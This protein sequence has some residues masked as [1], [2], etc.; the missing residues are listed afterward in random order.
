MD[1]LLAKLPKLINY[2]I[3]FF[4][5]SK[6]FLKFFCVQER[7]ILRPRKKILCTILQVTFKSFLLSERRDV[8]TQKLRFEY[9]IKFDVYYK[10]QTNIKP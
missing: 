9:E 6:V 3:K 7:Q 1:Y 5:V 8:R 2:C 10:L 4:K